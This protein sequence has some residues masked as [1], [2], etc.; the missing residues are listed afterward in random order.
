MSE[1]P[2]QPRWPG[3]PNQPLQPMQSVQ[4]SQPV[5]PAQPLYMPV[6]GLPPGFTPPSARPLSMGDRWKRL[7]RGKKIA[8]GCGGLIAACV[9]V[10]CL[11]GALLALAGS[12]PTSTGSNVASSPTSTPTAQQ[13]PTRTPQPAPVPTSTRAAVPTATPSATPTATA[14]AAIVTGSTF[15]GPQSA[16]STKYGPGGDTWD[17][18]GVSINVQYDSGVDGQPH[19]YEIQVGEDTT[20]VYWSLGQAQSYCY[21]FLPPDAQFKQSSTDSAGEPQDLY[22]SAWVA[23]T[24]TSSAQFGYDPTGNFTISY[25]PVGSTGQYIGCWVE[26]PA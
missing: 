1:T 9:I 13:S 10:S 18:N 2:Q 17:V 7:S 25:S 19:V 12:P 23:H 21:Q 3:Q 6:Y 11:G 15:A 24:W 26:I 16:W 14:P 4:P 5:P 8:A 22:T 20:A